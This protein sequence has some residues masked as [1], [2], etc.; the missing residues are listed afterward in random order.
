MARARI[1]F[2]LAALTS[3]GV[4]LVVATMPSSAPAQDA[5]VASAPP[6]PGV[7]AKMGRRLLSSLREIHHAMPRVIASQHTTQADGGE[8]IALLYE[9]AQYDACVG[10]APTKAAGREDCRQ[11][12]GELASCTTR[13]IVRATI[14]A[15]PRGRPEGTGG[16]LTLVARAVEPG[17]C[18]FE[19]VLA[20]E[21]RDV[22]GDGHPEIVSDLVSS[23]AQSEYRSGQVV[24]HSQRVLH[25]MREDLSEQARYALADWGQTSFETT[26]ESTAGRLTFADRDHD[27]HADVR[28]ESFTYDEMGECQQGPD[29]WFTPRDEDDDGDPDC[30]GEITVTDHRYDVATD[31]WL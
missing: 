6:I 12:L 3:I 2:C 19:R 30:T 17:G 28:I 16:A 5:G 4:V 24:T 10:A 8:D 14:A 26:T 11:E 29:G 21:R 13:E 22:D 9:Y 1:A 15:T 18:R 23:D 20:F 7:A 27:G 31:A 25:V